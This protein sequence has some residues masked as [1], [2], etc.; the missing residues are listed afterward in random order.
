MKLSKV[1]EIVDN[2]VEKGFGDW[3]TLITIKDISAGPRA[4][5]DIQGI[6]N[7]F[8]WEHGQ[9][10]IEPEKNLISQ[11]KDR[12]KA[13]PVIKH[14]YGQGIRN[15]ISCPKCEN[16]LRKS[17]KYCSICGQRV[18]TEEISREINHSEKKL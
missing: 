7:G 10:R 2:Y 16:H 13:L 14:I 9:I 12:D 3:N 17:D 1:K 5:S 18:N 4:C 15:V 11:S 6:Y 8:D